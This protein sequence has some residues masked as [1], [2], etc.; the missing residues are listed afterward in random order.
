MAW[1]LP[2]KLR[3][4]SR[5]EEREKTYFKNITNDM[6]LAEL[7]AI[8]LESSEALKKHKHPIVINVLKYLIMHDLEL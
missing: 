3:P 2:K 7:D 6:L 5:A 8:F 1:L 4:A